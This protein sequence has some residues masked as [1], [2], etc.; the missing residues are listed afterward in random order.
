[1]RELAITFFALDLARDQSLIE[2][3][4]NG[5]VNLLFLGGNSFAFYFDN[6]L[7]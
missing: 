2:N 3:E 1:M 5:D 6:Y 7:C 4:A